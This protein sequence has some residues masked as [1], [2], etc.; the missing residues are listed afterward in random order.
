VKRPHLRQVPDDADAPAVAIAYGP[1]GLPITLLQAIDALERAG[2]Y[3]TPEGWLERVG[4]DHFRA[5]LDGTESPD[6]MRYTPTVWL[7]LPC[8]TLR[9]PYRDVYLHVPGREPLDI[10]PSAVALAL[11]VCGYGVTPPPVQQGERVPR[12][13]LWEAPGGLGCQELLAPWAKVEEP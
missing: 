1:S 2:E 9:A 3:R 13:L 7:D 6:G 5:V 10:G 12:R 4:P 11:L 8:P